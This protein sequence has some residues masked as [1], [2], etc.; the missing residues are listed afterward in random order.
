ML[1]TKLSMGLSVIF[2]L[3]VVFSCNNSKLIPEN[4]LIVT[5]DVE[6]GYGPGIKQL[7]EKNKLSATILDWKSATI[8]KAKDFDLIIVT[9]TDRYLLDSCYVFNYDKPIL[10]YG[11]YGCAYLGKLNL[12]NGHPYT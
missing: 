4:I 6:G 2:I 9:G 3:L 12:K 5:S 7:L 1:K 8:E 10:A 11:P